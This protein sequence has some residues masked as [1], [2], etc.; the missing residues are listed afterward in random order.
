M[1]FEAIEFQPPT[2]NHHSHL[3]QQLHQQ[4]HQQLPPSPE[5]NSLDFSLTKRL[6]AAVFFLL[7]IYAWKQYIEEGEQ[8]DTIYI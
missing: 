4:H 7:V 2:S 6:L 1:I 5:L 8:S 3:Q